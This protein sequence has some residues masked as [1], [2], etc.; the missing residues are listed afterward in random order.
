[1]TASFAWT[2]LTSASAGLPEITKGASATDLLGGEKGKLE[3]A[4]VQPP[5]PLQPL[6]MLVLVLVAVGAFLAVQ[7]A[8]KSGARK[9]QKASALNVAP[10]EAQEFAAR[11]ARLARLGGGDGGRGAAVLTE[12]DKEQLRKRKPAGIS[13][14]AKNLQAA[15]RA[16][17][18]ARDA[19]EK[20]RQDKKGGM[21]W[22]DNGVGLEDPDGLNDSQL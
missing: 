1:M 9:L 6:M 4:V 10:T 11:Q 2:A 15:A 16:D 17:E 22:G 13:I 19:A 14:A 12:A 3:A 8:R 20:K 18:G 5:E 7:H 21:V